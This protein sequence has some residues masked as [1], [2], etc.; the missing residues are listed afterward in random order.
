M[1]EITCYFLIRNFSAGITL[2]IYTLFRAIKY[3]YMTFPYIDQYLPLNELKK[4]TASL[5]LFGGLRTGR[6]GIC[7]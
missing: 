1:K 2:Q 6:S 7:R 3:L 5:N 4:D